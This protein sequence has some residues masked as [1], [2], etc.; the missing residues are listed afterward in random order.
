M[1]AAQASIGFARRRDAADIGELSRIAIERG[2]VWRYTASHVT[3]LIQDKTKNVVVARVGRELAGFGV[4]TYREEQANLDL[5][6]VARTFRRRKVGSRIVSWLEKVALTGGACTVFV[7][8][9]HKNTGAIAFYRRLGYQEL[10][11]IAGYYQG[12]E[13]AVAM[14]KSLRPMI[15]GAR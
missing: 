8:V 1:I 9:R 7:Q 15:P 13:D 6:A 10:E 5:L 2:L 12:V 3:R 11:R 4:M 14:A